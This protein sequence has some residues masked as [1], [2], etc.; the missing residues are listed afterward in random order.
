MMELRQ[1]AACGT[2][3]LFVSVCSIFAPSAR[4]QQLSNQQVNASAGGSSVGRG[5]G[6]NAGVNAGVGGGFG[7]NIQSG[8]SSGYA[9]SVPGLSTFNTGSAFNSGGTAF[10]GSANPPTAV[11]L[12]IVANQSRSS[13]FEAGANTHSKNADSMMGQAGYLQ[14]VSGAGKYAI[15]G[16]FPDSTRGT[17]WPSPSEN[18]SFYG[19]GFAVGL[20]TWKPNF[21]SVVHLKISYL[22]SLSEEKYLWSAPKK[23]S[24]MRKN[25]TELQRFTNALKK[26]TKGLKPDLQ[27][28]PLG[29]MKE[30]LL[31]DQ[32][33]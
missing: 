20:P 9:A 23:R 21:D 33:K 12:K 26:K 5:E 1:F 16:D 10:A 4:S 14:K 18:Y 27:L 22:V 25:Q 6:V 28:S 29:N 30:S 7:G 3:L 8:G 2:L 17:G 24:N 15:L 31:P 11:Q 19:F 32:P 13:G